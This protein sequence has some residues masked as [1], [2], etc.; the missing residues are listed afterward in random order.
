M[1]I[2]CMCRKINTLRPASKKEGLTPIQTYELF[3]VLH[4]VAKA[5]G[6]RCP[7][8]SISSTK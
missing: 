8:R 7:P 3:D 5:T 1:C 2:C 4:G 6:Q